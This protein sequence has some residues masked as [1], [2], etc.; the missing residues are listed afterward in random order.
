M[1]LEIHKEITAINENPL[2][3]LLDVRVGA[4]DKEL[5]L[6]VFESEMYLSGD[7][8]KMRFMNASYK[9]ETVE[10][11]RISVE[12]VSH[13]QN[14]GSNST[15]AALN[16]HLGGLESAIRMLNQRVGVIVNV[17]RAMQAGEIPK[18]HGFLRMCRSL[19]MRLPAISS[20][21]YTQ[22]FQN[23]Y[24]DTLLLTYLSTLTKGAD[25]THELIDKFNL[26]SD[27]QSRR[28]AH[29]F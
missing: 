1:D 4:A 11:E 7:V 28:R 18:D 3:M 8:P 14:V 20:P 22:Q 29:M 25:T 24:N 27:K 5:P 12:Q 26:A 16:S 17:L 2:Y 23:E 6:Q 9:L 19:S 13:L 15:A 21:E 10:A